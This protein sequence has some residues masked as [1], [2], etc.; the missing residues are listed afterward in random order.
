MSSRNP[1][2]ASQSIST[3]NITSGGD[4]NLSQNMSIQNGTALPNNTKEFI[5]QTNILIDKL[6]KFSA[7]H[8]DVKAA[9][10]ELRNAIQEARKAN[11]DPPMIRRLMHSAKGLLDAAAKIA[12][13]LLP[14]VKLVDE[15]AQ[16]VP[17]IFG[18]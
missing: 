11:P 14:L 7:R 15:I 12:T 1:S 10:D 9:Q 18:R 16:R 4:V 13:P 2:N 17:M 5:Q 3:G 8:S 6:D